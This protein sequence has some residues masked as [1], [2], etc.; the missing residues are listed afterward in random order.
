MALFTLP[1]A[2]LWFD[3]RGSGIYDAEN[4]PGY[5]FTYMMN[6]AFLLLLATF[7]GANLHAAEINVCAASSLTD[8]LKEIGAAYEAQGGAHVSFNFAASSLLARQIE[9]GAPAD[10]FFSADD[11]QMDRLQNDGDIEAGSRRELLSNTLVVVAAA[12]STLT[13]NA[14]A[15]LRQVSRIA[16][17]DP[18]LVPVGVYT[19]SYLE[20]VGLWKELAEKIVPAENVRAGMAVVESGN[21]DVAFV[22]ATDARISKKVK[23]VLRI[24]ADEAPPILYPVALVKESPQ[25]TEAAKFLA[26]LASEVSYKVFEKFGFI[27]K[28]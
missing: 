12:D 25:K 5:A 9:E 15:D 22:Y 28:R 16:V 1:L 19:R 26:Y 14:V 3:L 6:R 17:G 4:N 13:F 8:A 27:V 24:P 7:A 18:K 23:I 21:A 10:V 11:A 20:K 2:A